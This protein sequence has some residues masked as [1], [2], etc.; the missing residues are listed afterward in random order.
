MPFRIALSG[1]NAASDEL[2]VV[3]N[4]I[5]NASTTGFK[6][7]RA[8]FADIYAVSNLGVTANAIGSGVKISAVSQQFTQGNISFT[9]NNLD[10]AVSGQGFFITSD[11]GIPYYT[12][13]GSFQVD[14]E[15]FVVNSQ[16]QIL[17]AYLADNNGNITGARGDLQLSTADIA[18][19][20]TTSVR[21]GA[22]LNANATGSAPYPALPIFDH[23]D[24]TTYSNSTSLT[25]YDSLGNG[26]L[27]TTYYRKTTN[28]NEW[29]THFWVTNGA[30]T[31]I[32]VIP[33]GFVAGQPAI[34]QFA[35]DGTLASVSPAL[36]GALTIDYGSFNPQTGAA[37]MTTSMNYSNTTQY[38]SP[39]S[40]VSLTQ[41]GYAT[42]RL[43]GID[44]NDTG[45]VLSRYTNGQTRTLGQVALA[46]FANSQGL[47]QIGDT[48]WA[49]TYDSGVA[50]VGPP[51]TGSLGLV[52][53]GALEG[54]NVDL[55]EQL[56][57]MITA[58]RNFQ[59]NAQ[60][61]STADAVTQTIINIR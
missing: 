46:N 52:Q 12:R 1:L 7:S 6:K 51:G 61:I 22:N 21:V 23:T 40:V 16:N 38:G 41:D 55:T 19:N 13:S 26:M 25:V 5:A 24:P 31:D 43:S 35:N 44:I 42:G 11:Q 59:A 37:N 20:T 45:V 36:G 18:P 32:E 49:E 60:V 57:T 17:Q 14:R 28:T 10:V 54:S 15:G 29:E 8:E 53:S 30:G 3:G 27:G 33:N 56:V 48:A 47:R 39:F 9:D 50:L 4:N 34:L 58:Q 2:R